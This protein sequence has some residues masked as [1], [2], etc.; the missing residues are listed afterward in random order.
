MPFLMKHEYDNGDILEFK[1][2][3][4][5]LLSYQDLLDVK[6][7]GK[8]NLKFE[9]KADEATLNGTALEEDRT[10]PMVTTPKEKHTIYALT[11]GGW[12]PLAFVGESMLLADRNF[13]DRMKKINEGRINSEFNSTKWWIDMLSPVNTIINPILYAYEGANR[14]FPSFKDFCTVFD[15]GINII[16]QYGLK[17]TV[18]EEEDY[19]ISYKI[20]EIL[21]VELEKE[22]EFLMK[23]SPLL[24]GTPD[25]KETK[26]EVDYIADEIDLPPKSFAYLLVLGYVY[27]DRQK[28][29]DY[30]HARGVLKKGMNDRKV[31]YN[32]AID[33][34]HLKMLML[35]KKLPFD[36]KTFFCTADF[37]LA[38]FWVGLNIHDVVVGDKD[39]TFSLDYKNMMPMLEDSK[40][41]QT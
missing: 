33:L 40:N 14:E 16:Q 29:K 30:H 37:H 3:G 25:M 23:I 24:T 35:S 12:L 7:S 5:I 19:R 15:E 21:K 11:F 2:D 18:Y 31:A 41:E 10:E 9:I 4:P 8:C 26:K 36:N 13:I 17:S 1:T 22:I 32:V 20:L 34:L 27:E 39:I 6:K 28:G 38:A